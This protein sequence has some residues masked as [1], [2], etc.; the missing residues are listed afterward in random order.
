VQYN[1][2]PAESK[3]SSVLA[4]TGEKELQEN[5]AGTD[6]GIEPGSSGTGVMSQHATLARAHEYFERQMFFA[7]L[8]RERKL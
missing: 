1:D 2:V 4:F 5:I 6:F 7:F 8:R 3:G